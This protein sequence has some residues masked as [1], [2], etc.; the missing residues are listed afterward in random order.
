M[1]TTQYDYD[2]LEREYLANPTLTIRGLCR[3]HG[4]KAYSSVAQYARDHGW[5]EKR[6]QVTARTTEKT[7][8][9]VSERIAEAEADEIEQ[10]RGDTLTVIRAA[11]YKFAEDLRDP[12]YRIPPSDLAKLIQLGLLITGQPTSRTEERRLDVV[13]S[14]EGLPREALRALAEATKPRPA[15]GIAEGSNS[16]GSD[17]A[18]RPN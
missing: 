5:Y 16:R 2:R 14:L 18:S 3:K 9:K 6:A 4:I 10:F 15:L 13:A 12:N 11:V 1:A 8:E 17:E 7:I